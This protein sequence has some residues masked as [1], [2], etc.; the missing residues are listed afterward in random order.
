M[1]LV[2]PEQCASMLLKCH[3]LRARKGDASAAAL[4]ALEA[5]LQLPYTD[6]LDESD[7]LLHSRWEVGGQRCCHGPTL[8]CVPLTCTPLFGW[9][10]VKGTQHVLRHVCPSR[11]C[12]PLRELDLSVCTPVVEDSPNPLVTLARR[13]QLVY[14]C[15]DAVELH[16]LPARVAAIQS[17]LRHARTNLGPDW[18]TPGAAVYEPPKGDKGKALP[19]AFPGIRL[20]PGPALDQEVTSMQW[21]LANAV[22]DRPPHEM[23][24]LLRADGELKVG[25]MQCRLLISPQGDPVR[26]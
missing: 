3:E 25:A 16:S 5:V 19:G 4:Q 24:W 11:V 18:V 17:L 7:E 13:F 9:P 12:V 2:A 20:V 1:V 10:M 14:A 22:L 26:V 8:G 21:R 6:I 23:Q 15:G